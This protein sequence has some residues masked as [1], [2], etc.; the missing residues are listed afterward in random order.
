MSANLIM[1]K[2]QRRAAGQKGFALVVVILV[3]LLAS[4]LASQLIML[5]STELKISHNIKSRA[6][7]H[8]LAEAGVNLGLFRLLD[9]PLDTPVNLGP[10]EDWDKFY[11][12]YKYALFLPTGRIT[13]YVSNESG[14]I[15]LNHASRGLMRLFITYE[16]GLEPGA[17]DIRIDTILDSIADWRDSD[18]MHRLNGAEN[19]Y[20]TNLDSPYIARN[21]PI[22]DPSEFFL[23]KGTEALTGKF[24]A[25]DIFTVHNPTGK[26]N[27]NSVTP[28]MLDFLTNG[29]KE[30]AAAYQAAK[31]EYGYNVRAVT[32]EIMGDKQYTLLHNYLN[33]NRGM[34]QYY[35]I[36][37]T[38]YADEVKEDMEQQN[39]APRGGIKPHRTAV[40]DSLLIKKSGR[41][42]IRMAWQERYR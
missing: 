11:Q 41:N 25:A 24:E 23:I 5:T 16:L 37:G 22:K 17:D 12:G 33:Y 32:A 4:V 36:V 20:Y 15:D 34:N 3:M 2:R 13:Y 26:I 35:F 38:G 29:N 42:F 6:I 28:A 19:E 31:K 1:N 8:F 30:A 39:E 40:T 10:E 14:K 9:R 27:F 21:G 18:D 7:G